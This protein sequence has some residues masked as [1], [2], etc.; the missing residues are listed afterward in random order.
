MRHDPAIR[1]ADKLHEGLHIAGTA[2]A[3]VPSC[4]MCQHHDPT[5]VVGVEH[6]GLASI[7]AFRQ[8]PRTKQFYRFGTGQIANRVTYSD[9]TDDVIA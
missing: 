7:A 5:T 6:K 8:L 2:S 1:E 4:V 9:M 3:E